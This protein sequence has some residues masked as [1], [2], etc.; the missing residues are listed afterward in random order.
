MK[1]ILTVFYFILLSFSLFGQN[2]IIREE[3]FELYTNE[4]EK[5]SITDRAYDNLGNLINEQHLYYENALQKW[6]PRLENWYDAAGNNIQTTRQF[7][8]SLDLGFHEESVKRQFNKNGNIIVEEFYVKENRDRK[9]ILYRKIESEYLENCSYL[10][11]YYYLDNTQEIDLQELKLTA[12]LLILY[13]KNCDYAHTVNASNLGLDLNSLKSQVR[14]TFEP[15]RTGGKRRIVER[16][17]CPKT[18]GCDTWA[19]RSRNTYD[20]QGRLIIEESGNP[21][22]FF[23]RITSTS[24]EPDQIVTTIE[25]YAKFNNLPTQSLSGRDIYINDLDGKVLSTQRI[26]A[27]SSFGTHLEYNEQGLVQRSF[28]T[29]TIKDSTGV[30]TFRDTTNYSYQFYCDDLPSEQVIDFGNYKNK[31]TF[32]YLKPADCGPNNSIS[33]FLIFP[34]PASSLINIE[35]EAFV[36]GKYTMDIFDM[37]GRHIRSVTNYRSFAQN[38]N[39]DDLPNGVYQLSIQHIDGR[40]TKPFIV[41]R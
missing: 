17:V 33:D 14:I 22:D 32:S 7:F 3:Q 40:I 41:Q 38:I 31:T 15:T 4:W 18:F 24:Y 9:K 25:T 20:N 8:Q 27:L 23:R 37:T 5:V 10:Q 13:D 28:F 11:R 35:N 12:L 1:N 26:E 29:R 2:P 16:L 30:V 19:V 21:N 6:I 39:I 34:N 36:N